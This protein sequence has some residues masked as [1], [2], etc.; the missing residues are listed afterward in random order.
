MFVPESSMP[1]TVAQQQAHLYFQAAYEARDGDALKLH[2]EALSAALWLPDGSLF[3]ASDESVTIEQLSLHSPV[4]DPVLHFGQH[5]QLD[6]ATVLRNFAPTD[7]QGRLAEVD[8]ESLAYCEPYL[9]FVGSHSTKRKN[10]RAKT[11][12]ILRHPGDIERLQTL[13]IDPNRYLLGRVKLIP[14]AQ[15]HLQFS[16]DAADAAY[17]KRQGKGNLLMR[18]LQDDPHLRPF[19]QTRPR[20]KKAIAL[21]GKDNGFDIE[22]MVVD[23]NRIFLGLRGPVLRGW[24]ILLEIEVKV[25]RSGWLKLRK[26]GPHGER[27]RKHFLNLQ[28]LG[29]RDLCLQGN[30]LLILAGPTQSLSGP[31]YIFQLAGGLNTLTMADDCDLADPLT[32]KL[33]LPTGQ[34]FDH[35]EGMTLIPNRDPA[36]VLI[37]YDAPGHHRKMPANPHQGLA[38]IFTL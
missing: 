27:Y 31:A 7:A 9:W 16:R 28:G 10:P 24:S 35:P 29:I 17:L 12:A 22:G 6:L 36:Q 15:G 18:A 23:G 30:D 25:T 4:A 2:A 34:G 32:V 8:I 20:L 13:V 26:I 11:A 33:E 3:L 21:P 14:D 5:Q 1:S 37:V 19:L 38:D